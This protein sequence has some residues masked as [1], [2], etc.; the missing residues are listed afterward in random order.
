M[1]Q[2]HKKEWFD[3][4]A[5]WQDLYPYM[6]PEKRFEDTPAEIKKVLA[7]IK[8][9]GKTVL[10]LCCGPGRCAITLARRGF[11]VTG[12]DRTKFLLDK[13]RARA[14][15]TKARVE[16]IQNDM[17]DFI[18]PETYDMVLSMF[19]SFGYFDD[20]K[21]DLV[22]L[23]NILTS[24]K[25]GGTCLI[26]VMGKEILARIYQPTRSD[27]LP[28]GTKVI[29]RSEIFSEWTR[30]RNE[31]IIIKKGRSKSFTFHHTIY[32]GQELR[33]RMENAGFKNVKL[34]GNFDGD[35]Y[36][37]NSERLIVVGYKR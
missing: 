32:S 14:R 35:E 23:K 11:K 37:M 1:A 8:P 4:D 26:E 20:K 30:V 9:K 16:W 12:V 25:P 33:D 28:D 10:D 36:G 24:L 17:R 15:K 6:F 34:Y 13:A 27:I 22:V 19:T 3:N 18:R 2:K 5:F 7:L 29:G 31:W 21:E